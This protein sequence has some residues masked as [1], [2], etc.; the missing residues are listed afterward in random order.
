MHGQSPYDGARVIQLHNSASN[1]ANGEAQ[2]VY[3]VQY[4]LN[5]MEIYD[6]I[7]RH[8]LTIDNDLNT[9]NTV[10]THRETF[11]Y[12][13]SLQNTYEQGLN[14]VLIELFAD[15]AH[16]LGS[17]LVGLPGVKEHFVTKLLVLLHEVKLD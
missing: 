5:I 10:A 17:S 16:D 7:D 13:K 1:R 9:S 4:T 2:C 8:P 12:M 3:I 11:S 14:L 15:F 6:C